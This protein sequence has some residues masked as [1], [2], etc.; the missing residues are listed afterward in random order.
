MDWPWNGIQKNF[1]TLVF[2]SKLIHLVFIHL[3]FTKLNF[4][5]EFLF[6]PHL[7][8]ACFIC[9]EFKCCF[10]LKQVKN[11]WFVVKQFFIYFLCICFFNI[12]LWNTLHC[13]FCFVW[14]ISQFHSIVINFFA[15]ENWIIA[16]QNFLSCFTFKITVEL[17]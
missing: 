9:W 10:I 5:S 16:I 13:N 6:I 1:F 3:I 8:N 17:T 15:T 11:Y 7:Q 4:S 12:L 2:L 14:P